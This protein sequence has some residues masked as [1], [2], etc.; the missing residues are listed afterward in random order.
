MLTLFTGSPGAG[1]TAAMVDYLRKLDGTRP[2]YVDGLNGF[3]LPHNTCDASR[4][5]EELPDGAILV[6]DEVQRVWRARAPG[7]KV[8]DAVQALETHRHRGIDV[9]MTTQGPNLLDANVR[10][11]VGRHVHI[12]DTGWLGRHWYEW[13]ECNQG[14]AWKTC[15][16]K[17]KYKL[18]KAAFDLYIS[19]S[20]HTKPV[21][22]TPM[23]LYLAIGVIAAAVVGAV[24]VV[25]TLRGKTSAPVEA[26]KVEHSSA[27]PSVSGGGLL[28]APGEGGGPVVI[29]DRVDW[30]PRISSRPE[31]APAF[32]QV[33]KVSA[34]PVIVGCAT[35]KGRTRCYTQQGT[36]A[37]LD[38]REARVLLEQP[39]F[40][41][42]AVETPAPRVQERPARENAPEAPQGPH[43]IV[44]DGR[45]A[46]D[47]LR[48]GVS[49]TVGKQ[50]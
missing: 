7:S 31:S 38:D 15:P 37:G 45:G 4:W 33:R 22:K 3:K 39:R 46:R 50:Q 47:P 49:S 5:H 2:L 32:D 20:L 42:Y 10:T 36:D 8:P 6:I 44:M 27:G 18:P 34:M 23:A 17:A 11:L 25:N 28:R 21:R 12:R 43:L 9:Y 41:A 48:A 30:I 19:S 13:P 1:K 14:L 26:K 40:N 16:V 35:F 24:V 29:D